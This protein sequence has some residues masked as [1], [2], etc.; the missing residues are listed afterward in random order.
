ML[1]LRQSS[2]KLWIIIYIG[3]P[4][5]PILFGGFIRLVLSS[6]TLTTTTINATELSIGIAL[7]CIFINQDL[8]RAEID[9]L[10]S[11]KDK[12]CDIKS[13]SWLFSISCCF[14]IG[15]Y[16]IN[17]ICEAVIKYHN[18][19]TLEEHLHQFQIFNFFLAAIV[20]LWSISVQK[21]YKL[22]VNI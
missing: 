7:L 9:M 21:S 2:T 16:V 3:L 22:E 12:I 18:V 19:I 17:V 14:F 20:I 4:I 11:D 13:T 1:S 8:K 15:F 5:I 10:L 6:W